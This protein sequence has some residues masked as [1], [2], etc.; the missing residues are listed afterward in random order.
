MPVTF[1]LRM[2]Y[3]KVQTPWPLRHSNDLTVAELLFLSYISH[4]PSPLKS[5]SQPYG[6]NFYSWKAKHFCFQVI[7]ARC[8]PCLKQAQFYFL[9]TS[10]SPVQLQ[11]AHSYYLPSR[12]LNVTSSGKLSLSAYHKT[13]LGAPTVYYIVKQDVLTKLLSSHLNM[14]HQKRNSTSN[15]LLIIRNFIHFCPV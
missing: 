4:P 8:S 15:P 6:T 3:S 7:C 5:K 1:S 9:L 12:S 2:V 14:P 11:P 13:V 10:P